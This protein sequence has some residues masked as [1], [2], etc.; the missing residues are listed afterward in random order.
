[1][2]T[3]RAAHHL[4]AAG[5]AT[6]R[7]ADDP[8]AW[9]PPPADVYGP[10]TWVVGLRAGPIHRNVAVSI[11]PVWQRGSTAWRALRW[12]PVEDGSEVLPL[13]SLLPVFVGEIGIVRSDARQTAELR[14]QG[15][16]APP[17][18]IAGALADHAG[19]HRVAQHTADR[20]VEEV[21]QRLGASLDAPAMGPVATGTVGPH[22]GARR[23]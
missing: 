6:R 16:Y 21:A 4:E 15:S 19:L 12:E 22:L 8:G 9:L 14:L 18:G 7:F 20:L 11:G 5:D 2:I 23:P 13:E 1:M 3:V 10:A 17:G